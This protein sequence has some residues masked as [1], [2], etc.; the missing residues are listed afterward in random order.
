M[1]ASAS[2]TTSQINSSRKSFSF[3]PSFHFSLSHFDYCSLFFFYYP[4][5]LKDEKKIDSFSPHHHLLDPSDDEVIAHRS[6]G[7]G[8]SSSLSQHCV[9]LPSHK[10]RDQTTMTVERRGEKSIE[11]SRCARLCVKSTFREVADWIVGESLCTWSRWL[12]KL[13]AHESHDRRGGIEGKESGR[14]GIEDVRRCM[15]APC[16]R[17][18][19]SCYY[20]Y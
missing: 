5:P 20:G 11:L 8:E 14:F 1:V 6:S 15:L 7:L 16:W 4:F 18:C 13:Q 3:L 12:I 10:R 9:P 19:G 17:S 2:F